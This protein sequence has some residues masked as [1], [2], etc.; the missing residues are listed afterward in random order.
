M[1][2]LFNVHLSLYCIKASKRQ[3]ILTKN[4]KAETAAM[5]DDAVQSIHMG[6]NT[7]K[8]YQQKVAN[9]HFNSTDD[10]WTKAGAELDL[11]KTLYSTTSFIYL[12]RFFCEGTEVLCPAKV[13]AKSDREL[14]RRF[15]TIHDQFLSVAAAYKAACGRGADPLVCYAFYIFRCLDLAMQ[16][17]GRIMCLDF[18]SYQAIN[19]M[20]APRS[21]GGWAISHIGSFLSNEAVDSLVEYLSVMYSLHDATDDVEVCVDM[22]FGYLCQPMVFSRKGHD[23]IGYTSC[24]WI[25]LPYLCNNTGR[26]DSSIVFS[27]MA[28]DP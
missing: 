16:S 25:L 27:Q 23:V 9:V 1:D 15:T 7:N 8:D 13:F 3:G 10:C 18:G 5:I 22:T 6:G 12:N 26:N 28:M 20:F 14:T 11:N 17:S 19:G 21:M 24:F 4:E 2:S